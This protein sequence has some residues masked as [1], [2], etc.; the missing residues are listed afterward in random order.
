MRLNA[1]K[2]S[3]GGLKF[4]T[5]AYGIL[6]M[7]KLKAWHASAYQ[8]GYWFVCVLKAYSILG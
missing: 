6:G 4:A 2:R 7:R 3:T 1:G 8:E 5:K